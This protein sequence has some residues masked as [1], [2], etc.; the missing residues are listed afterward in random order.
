[1]SDVRWRITNSMLRRSLLC[2]LSLLPAYVL[3]LLDCLFLIEWHCPFSQQASLTSFIM[4]T[5]GTFGRHGAAYHTGGT[6]THVATHMRAGPP[7][8]RTAANARFATPRLQ[9]WR[10]RT[11]AC[12]AP[13]CTRR[14]HAPW[15]SWL[16]RATTAFTRHDC[17]RKEKLGYNKGRTT[18]YL[19]C[20][21]VH[22]HPHITSSHCAH[23]H[24][25][26]T[27]CTHQFADGTAARTA[28]HALAVQHR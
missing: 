6:A 12:A 13:R 23:P 8:L 9:R 28:T 26:P 25:A 15:P 4:P 14:A 10:M 2:A 3:F 19:N 27:R 1:M 7:L 24:H 17:M 11:G 5:C 22:R 16:S 20:G 18:L 21:L